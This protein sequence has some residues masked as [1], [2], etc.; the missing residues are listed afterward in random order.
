MRNIGLKWVYIV[1]TSQSGWDSLIRS[2]MTRKLEFIQIKQTKQGSRKSCLFVCLIHPLCLFAKIR[3]PP[4]MFASLFV[5]VHLCIKSWARRRVSR[6]PAPRHC[7]DWSLVPLDCIR[8]TPSRVAAAFAPLT[9]TCTCTRA[10]RPNQYI[11]L[12]TGP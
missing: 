1:D 12:S 8:H 10:T 11:H 2:H 3:G 7:N 5:C 6:H 4:C 9:Q